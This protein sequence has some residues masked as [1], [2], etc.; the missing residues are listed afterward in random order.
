MQVFIRR[1]VIV[2][3][4]LLVAA[5][6]TAH[7]QLQVPSAAAPISNPSAL[8]DPTF[9]ADVQPLLDADKLFAAEVLQGGGAVF[10]SWFADD[11]ITMSNKQAVEQGKSAIASG[12]TWKPADYQLIWSPDGARMGPH[13]EMGIT[14]GHF[15]GHTKDNQGN[16]VVTH[17]RY[18]TVWEKDKSGRWK[19][20]ADTSN[21][22]PAE[23][24]S[25]CSIH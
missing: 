12:T 9:H 5:T 19:V 17:G 4:L 21:E 14:W 22:A 15:E 24:D 23:K 16:L 13:G 18:L 1:F 20:L 3:T 25:C 10:A 11:A 6:L 8:T 2:F 7:A